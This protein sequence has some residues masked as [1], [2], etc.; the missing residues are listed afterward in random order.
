MNILM[1]TRPI[2]PPWDEASKN[3]AYDIACSIPEHKFHILTLPA[4]ESINNSNIIQHAI[5]TQPTL[6]RY[7]QLLLLKYLWHQHKQIDA[8]HYFFTPTSSTSPL[9]RYLTNKNRKKS[10]QSVACLPAHVL[11][12]PN[13][14]KK[15]LFADKIITYSE[16]TKNQIRLAGL[17]NV[18]AIYPGVNLEKFNPTIETYQLKKKLGIENEKVVLYAGEYE[19]LQ[20]IDDIMKAIPLVIRSGLAVKF[21]FA[22]RIKSSRDKKI[23][24]RVKNELRQNNL[25][26]HVI[27]LNTVTDMPTLINLSHV[28]ILP[29]R[30]MSGK[31]DLPLILIE[32]LACAKPIIVTDIAPMNEIIQGNVG[33]K[34][35]P[36]N[37]RALAQ[38]IRELLA[39]EA[40]Y[41]KI[42]DSCRKLAEEK[43][44][45][46]KIANKY[47]EIYGSIG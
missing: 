1:V 15:L 42:S 33:R 9:L 31:F 11:S 14:I 34:I 12:D 47:A 21:I 32:A 24:Q 44:D 7:Q 39:N 5:Y 37:F 28:C 38:S 36:G 22:C 16:Y 27:F 10:I 6:S 41:K 26:D 23:E 40:E 46:K 8:Y 45:I 30:E 43:F 20:A 19:R 4:N 17:N 18:D 2:S 3:F 25:S 13:K 29:A 35:D